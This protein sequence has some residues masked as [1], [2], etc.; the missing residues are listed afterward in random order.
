VPPL[1]VISGDEFVKAAARLGY[2]VERQRGSHMMLRC[3]GRKPLTVPRHDELDRKTLRGLIRDAG[4]SVE[5][6]IELLK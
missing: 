1:P 2:A 3:P 6:F 4:V 5:E